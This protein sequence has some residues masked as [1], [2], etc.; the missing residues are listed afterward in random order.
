MRFIVLAIEITWLRLFFY[1]G[2]M[3]LGNKLLTKYVIIKEISNFS[4]KVINVPIG[5]DL[6][7]LKHPET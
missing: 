4:Y 7:R 1:M 5:R 6:N 2:K 3:C